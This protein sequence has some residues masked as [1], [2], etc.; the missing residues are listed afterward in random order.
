M[1]EFFDLFKYDNNLIV[2]K[3]VSDSAFNYIT[4]SLIHDNTGLSFLRGIL[5]RRKFIYFRD[6]TDVYISFE[7]VIITVMIK[8]T[9]GKN[10]TKVYH[11]R[12]PNRYQANVFYK[13]IKMLS[14]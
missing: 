6:I 7:K 8:K 13:G 11:F 5:K 2:S 1:Q 14:V 10:E 4:L 12:F 3:Y 9:F